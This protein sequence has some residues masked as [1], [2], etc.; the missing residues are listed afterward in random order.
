MNASVEQTPTFGRSHVITYD[1]FRQRV[2]RYRPSDLLP[3]IAATAIRFF[4]KETWD[5]VHSPW[6]LAEAAK[7]SIVSGNDHRSTAVTPECIF[8]ICRA[9]NMLDDPAR[10]KEAGIVG[11]PE[12]YLTRVET[13][14]FPYQM[15]S[16]EEISRISALF[17]TVD[18]IDTEILDT[19]L[20]A[21]ILGCSIDEYITAGFVISTVARAGSGY[22]DVDQPEIWERPN[23]LADLMSKETLEM[24]FRRH[25]L[26]TF[27][28]F[29]DLARSARQSNPKLQQHEYNP[30]QGHPFIT[31]K[32]GAHIAPQ[33]HLVYQRMAPAAIYYAGVRSLSSTD[34]DKFTRDLGIVF[35][36]YVGRQL[37]LVPGVT[38]LEE[39][40]Y[41]KSKR[42][43][44]WIVI[45]DNFVLLVEAKSTRL[46]QRARMGDE[47][48]PEDVERCIGEAYRQIDRT[49][50]LIEDN[51]PAFA[52]IPK[53]LPR[54]GVV[55]TLE[56]YWASTNPFFHRLIPT[57]PIPTSIALSRQLE[58]AVAIANSGGVS[59]SLQHS[60]FQT[61]EEPP[62]PDDWL[63]DVVVRNPILESA[64]NRNSL[65]KV[66]KSPDQTP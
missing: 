14:Q 18:S 48:L 44:D 27:S 9:Y 10:M 21:Q 7:V 45:G 19:A 39:I 37:K 46:T 13:S 4:E 5:A 8:E 35:E 52:V 3:A 33:L 26:T 51:H 32:N 50:R 1:D 11:T 43:V 56:P 41:E 16:F 30:L 12:A 58:R 64:W 6:A 47:R 15:S 54:Y 57:S 25:Y 17:E 24:L 40:E 36:D 61:L 59:E 29:K 34:A 66:R 38:V 22:F 63:D 49:E 65:G 60:L 28:E 42:S 62:T 20:I 55:A 53:E 2:R 31:L 23:R